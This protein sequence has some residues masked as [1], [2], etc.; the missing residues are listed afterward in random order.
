MRT[1]KHTYLEKGK[2][3]KKKKRRT[4]QGKNRSRLVYVVSVTNVLEEIMQLTG[5][6]AQ[7]RV[8]GDEA[9]MLS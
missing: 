6:P 8:P 2:G 1:Q 3:K 7:P 5:E 4:S 9:V